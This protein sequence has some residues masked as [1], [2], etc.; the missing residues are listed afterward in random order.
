MTATKDPGELTEF[1]AGQIWTTDYPVR[2]V[3][4]NISA[5]TTVVRLDD[6]GLWVHS[7]GP[8]DDL[9]AARLDALGLV[10]HIVAPG[11]FH[12]LHVTDFKQR[13]PD[14]PV[15]VCPGIESKV[16]D[17]A[18][19]HILDDHEA[20]TA[21]SGQIDQRLV[22]GAEMIRE[23]AFLH[24]PSQTLILTDLLENIGDESGP[25]DWK[26]RAW[27]K[28][29]FRMWNHPKPAPEYQLS[30][31]HKG[32]MKRCLEQVLEWDFDRVIISHGAN[33]TTGAKQAVREAWAAPLAYQ[34]D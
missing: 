8:V 5:R 20:P 6:G 27:W 12:Y 22:R 34:G 18:Y 19:D 21:W 31:K 25:V 16:P 9:L 33:I 1:V 17:L 11:T 26:L 3:G 28:V 10:R 32:V 24:R 30:T 2:F 13:Y 23:L 7:P 29:V 4:I 15:W 14:A